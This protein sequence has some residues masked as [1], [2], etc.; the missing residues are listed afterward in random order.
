MII[1]LPAVGLAQ[2]NIVFTF[3][4]SPFDWPLEKTVL[5]FS[6]GKYLNLKNRYDKIRQKEYLNLGTRKMKK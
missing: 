6:L 3:S 1:D 2:P 5:G 4:G